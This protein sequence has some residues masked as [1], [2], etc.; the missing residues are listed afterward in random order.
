MIVLHEPKIIILKARKVGSTSLEIALSRFATDT[1]IITPISMEDEETRTRLGYRG[2]QNFRYRDAELSLLEKAK[3]L[4]KREPPQKYF[5]HIPAA[6]AR[7][8]L[9]S[10]LWDSY[11]KVATIRNPFD[12]AISMY[13]WKLRSKSPGQDTSFED[14]TSKNLDLI[15]R[16]EEIYKIDGKNIIDVMIRYDHLEKDIKNLENNHPSLSGLWETFSQITAKSAVRPK[17]S[18][19][20]EMFRNAPR[21]RQLISEACKDDIEAYGFAVP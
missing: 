8:R 14:W 3:A 17:T 19:I 5:N 6:L 12:A 4:L 16:N 1:S 11:T 13:F 15:R 2:P 10:E 21:A 18:S 20:E 7:Q 9:G